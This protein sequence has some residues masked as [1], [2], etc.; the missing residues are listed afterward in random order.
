MA[1]LYS[2]NGD[3][4]Y[5]RVEDVFDTEAYADTFYKAAIEA[6]DGNNIFWIPYIM[7]FQSGQLME[8]LLMNLL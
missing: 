7:Y 4:T 3:T 6:A 5:H 8:K 1:G 2:Q